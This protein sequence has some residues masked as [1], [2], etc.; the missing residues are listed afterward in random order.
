MVNG[1]N[2]AGCRGPD[3]MA[4]RRGGQQFNADV[5]RCHIGE[6]QTQLRIIADVK[7]PQAA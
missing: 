2:I 6:R 3:F 5:I 1:R 4:E 7:A